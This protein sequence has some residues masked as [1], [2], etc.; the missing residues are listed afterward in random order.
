VQ[1]VWQSTRSTSVYQAVRRADG[2]PVILKKCSPAVGLPEVQ[3]HLQLREQA[4]RLH[5]TVSGTTSSTEVQTGTPR[6]CNDGACAAVNP[7]LSFHQSGWGGAASDMQ[8][9]LVYP[10][11]EPL[12]QSCNVADQVAALQW[13]WRVAIELIDAVREL[14]ER[15]VAHRD[16]KP[17]NIMCDPET[18]A[19]RLIDVEFALW[20]ADQCATVQPAGTSIWWPPRQHHPYT[21]D[22][23]SVEIFTTGALLLHF[24]LYALGMADD[25]NE[26]AERGGYDEDS[27]CGLR[28]KPE[29]AHHAWWLSG[30]CEFLIQM[31]CDNPAQRPSMVEAARHI[32]QCRDLFVIGSSA[33]TD[34]AAAVERPSGVVSQ[35]DAGTY[36]CSRQSCAFGPVFRWL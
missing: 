11:L 32:R 9:T 30:L 16:L 18:G 20:P 12:Q 4:S 23:R 26:P 6:Q 21:Y 25:F 14:H 31:M 7:L 15:N 17:D 36:V 27:P 29:V 13:F 19:L 3:A 34:G 35:E 22:A 24:L 33:R 28:S 1:L 5:A 8:L 2:R 10:K